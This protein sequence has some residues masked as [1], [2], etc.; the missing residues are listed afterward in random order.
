MNNLIEFE[1]T[2][3]SD[4]KKNLEKFIKKNKDNYI[5]PNNHWE[6]N[7]WNIT[8][9]LKHK[10]H[11]HK[12]K[13]IYFRSV[14]D[15][16]IN[17][18]KINI[19]LPDT[20]INFA[21]ATFCEI[22]RHKVLV[23]YKRII[24]AIQAIEFALI[25]QNKKICITEI[26]IETLYQAEDYLRS[27]YNDPWSIAK[28]I[29]FI[30]NNIIIKFRLNNILQWATS[31]EYVQPT[32][33]DRTNKKHIEGIQSKIPHLE[34]ILALADIYHK[35]NHPP[36]KVVTCFTVLAMF[37]P[38]RASEILS[39]PSDCIISV[40]QD[41]FPLIGIQW[42]PLKG[43]QPLIKYA[44]NQEFGQ[45]ASNAVATLLDIGKCA[46]EAAQWYQAHPDKLYLPPPFKYLRNQPI[47]LWETAQILGKQH[48]IRGCHAFRYGF[49]KP[50]HRTTDKKRMFNKE[51]HWVGLYAF[52]ELQH[53]ILSQLPET[54]PILDGRAKQYWHESL[55]VLPKNILT[56]DIDNLEYV[57]TVIDIN[58][59]NK[60]LGSNPD[61]NT[62]FSRNHKQFES[63]KPMYI[64]THQFRHLLNTLAQSKFI[65]QELI[66]F[67]SGRKSVQQ[68]GVYDHFSQEAIIEAY[69][70]L[71]NRVKEIKQEGY[72]YKKVAAS[73]KINSIT[74]DEALKIELGSI[75]ITRYGICR[76]DYSL[77]PCPKDKD[78]G[79]C[80]EFS[81]IK[82][83]KKHEIEAHHQVEILETAVL[84][85]KKADDN[86]HSG[87]KRWLNINE[88]KLERW[89][90]I[91]AFLEDNSI[92]HGTM[93]TLEDS[94]KYHQTKVGLA[95]EVRELN[96]N[97]NEQIENSI[98]NMLKG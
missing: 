81:V 29:E 17:K 18:S 44:V 19:A 62:I 41:K 65:S 68:N 50:I 64:T 84:H 86:G 80:S 40:E 43:G 92:Q 67:W 71:G 14:Q 20:L 1:I 33:S 12:L 72:L 58:R 26:N 7:I 98:I 78:C 59:I 53:F 56:P 36:D 15:N 31:I 88:P 90:K 3:D 82:G 69:K 77:T 32:R 46:R 9:F 13:K 83:N 21:K 85:A 25:Q 51:S 10:N 93:F 61:G 91:R 16:S 79:N 70:L 75:H 57:P 45:L 94:S 23:E 24:F 2:S 5:F 27:K 76:H 11:N 60:Q 97:Q 48:N 49:S 8:P 22:M 28:N 95:F 37:A 89:K 55:F 42:R 54:F 47:T 34:E 74:Y 63:G 96:P 30:I 66:A 35:S 6:E 38:S 4:H 52:H 87:A 73:S 39:L